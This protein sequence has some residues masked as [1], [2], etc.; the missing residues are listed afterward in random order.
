MPVATPGIVV[1]SWICHCLPV[2]SSS[3]VFCPRVGAAPRAARAARPSFPPFSAS[4]ALAAGDADSVQQHQHIHVGLEH[5]NV[6]VGRVSSMSTI[7]AVATV[8]TRPAVASVCSRGVTRRVRAIVA[9]GTLSS[10]ASFTAFSAL[11][12]VGLKIYVGLR[13]YCDWELETEIFYYDLLV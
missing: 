6:D 9:S 1:R 10:V 3:V 4:S 8:L 12:P 13:A 11:S 7:A 2:Y 5:V